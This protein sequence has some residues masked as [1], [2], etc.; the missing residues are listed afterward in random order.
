MIALTSSALHSVFHICLCPWSLRYCTRLS[1]FYQNKCYCEAAEWQ[2]KGLE[3]M[4]LKWS[5]NWEGNNSVFLFRD[6]MT[7][8]CSPI[9]TLV[10]VMTHKVQSIRWKKK[11]RRS[12]LAQL[13]RCWGDAD[14][15]CNLQDF[16]PPS[17]PTYMWCRAW[18]GIKR[19]LPWP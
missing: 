12:R 8:T 16:R 9:G 3:L 6:L 18:G 13:S 14:A 19:Q 15:S 1:E 17:H 10:W 7:N 11:S 2:E 5:V 4:C